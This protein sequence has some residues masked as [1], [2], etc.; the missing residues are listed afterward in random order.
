MRPVTYIYLYNE[1]EKF[2]G[3]G[4]CSLLRAIEEKGSLRAA[5][6]SL[7]IS[8]SKAMKIIHRAE[9]VL[10]FSLTEKS[11]GGKGGGGSYLTSEAKDFLEK[12]EKFR[13]ECYESNSRIYNEI[14]SK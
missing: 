13:E 2:F 9:K 10:N 5:A 1:D 12:Y 4:P 11:I 14:F 7:N 3:N 8:Y 6:K